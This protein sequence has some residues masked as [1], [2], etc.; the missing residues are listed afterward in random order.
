MDVDLVYGLVASM[1]SSESD[2]RWGLTQGTE[3]NGT[4]RNGTAESVT[5]IEGSNIMAPFALPH[6]QV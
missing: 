6:N 4:E 5:N 2:K 3:Q 1:A